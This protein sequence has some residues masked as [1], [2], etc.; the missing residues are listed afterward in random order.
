MNVCDLSMSGLRF[1]MFESAFIEKGDQLRVK[2]NLE[3]KQST[4]IDK[5]VVVIFV[6]GDTFGCEFTNLALE[7][8]E[9]GF[10]LFS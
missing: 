1:R 9:L 3:I 7:E 10:F 8:K 6:N 5:E 4:L 2:F